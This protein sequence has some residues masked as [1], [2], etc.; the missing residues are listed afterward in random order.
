ML[1]VVT[2]VGGP[3]GTVIG[4]AT[5]VIVIR[6]ALP[7]RTI[8]TQQYDENAGCY[9]EH[10]SEEIDWNRVKHNAGNAVAY[11]GNKMPWN[12]N[13]VI[14]KIKKKPKKAKKSNWRE[15]Y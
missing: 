12:K 5:A 7:K 11:V 14:G 15:G 6:Q 13:K 2:F 10:Y 8:Q 4:V 9:I 3:I 1:N